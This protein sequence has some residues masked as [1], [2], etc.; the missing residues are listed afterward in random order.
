KSIGMFKKVTKLSPHDIESVVRLADLY[1]QQGLYSD[2]RSQYMVLADQYMKTGQNDSAAGIFKKMLEL[3]PENT[4]MQTR[5]A[6]IYLKL[7]KKDDAKSIFFKAAESLHARGSLDAADEALDRV[8]KIDP[9]S[10]EALIL[11]AQVATES[12][13]PE[14]ASA[15]LEKI[16]DI[17]SRPEA[18]NALLNAL[19][20]S[21]RIEDA[22]PIIS[23]L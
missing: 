7:G 3:D 9:R 22:A 14:K 2:A 5:L 16:S 13:K 17:D 10:S 1:S 15:C 20:Q 11:R 6:D 23:K 12:N 19:L 21:G 8:L 18:L 4:G